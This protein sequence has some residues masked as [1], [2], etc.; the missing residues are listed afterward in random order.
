MKKINIRT[1]TVTAIMGAVGFVLML[2]E[3]PLAFIIP[4]FI[5]FDFSEIPALI[6]AFGFGPVYGILVCLIKN[7]LHLFVTSSGGVGE[8][9]NFIL[10]AIFVGTAG[11]VYKFNRT[12]KGAV[13]GSVLGA[14]VMAV[15]SVVTNLFFVYPAFSVIYGLPME[16]ILGMY[17][18]LLPSADN[19]LKAL[20]IFNLPFNFAKGMIHAGIC[21]V[22]YKSISPI[23][24][25]GFTKK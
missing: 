21:F 20:L 7:L 14:A 19:L 10:G 11:F 2:L 12:R 22:I 24:K 9:S 13:I 16:A 3:F 17:K 8:F 18:A 1:F 23:L 5:K 25:K 4:S 15:I 6:T